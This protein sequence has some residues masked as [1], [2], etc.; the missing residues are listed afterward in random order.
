MGKIY[1]DVPKNTDTVQVSIPCRNDDLLWSFQVVFTEIERI[2]TRIVTIYDN[3]C[4]NESKISVQ[5][6]IVNNKNHRLVEFEYKI[7]EEDLKM[8]IKLSVFFSK[9]YRMIIAEW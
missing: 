8:A 5:S 7:E 4:E 3:G 2:K 9:E 6:K 1:F